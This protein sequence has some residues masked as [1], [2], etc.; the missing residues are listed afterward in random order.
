MPKHHSL[1]L[2]LQSEYLQT[3]DPQKVGELYRTLV[4]L[5]LKINERERLLDDEDGVLDL[6]ADICMRLME[7]G[8][9]VI[10]S[11]P[12]AYI[13]NAMFYYSK[14]RASDGRL[15][16]Y[17]D[18]DQPVEQGEV[19]QYDDYAGWITSQ[20]EDGSEATKLAAQV[21][22]SRINWKDIRKAIEDKKFRAEFSKKMKEVRDAVEEDLQGSRV[23]TVV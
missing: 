16:P 17:E 19:E 9:E 20:I 4:N 15:V 8:K 12:S 23:H 10:C 2:R 1:I 3:K 21:I 5:E 11:A 13:R 7:T 22:E 14:P 18:S 6:A